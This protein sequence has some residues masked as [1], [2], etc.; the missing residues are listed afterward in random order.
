[1]LIDS[2]VMAQHIVAYVAWMWYTVL[3]VRMNY[4]DLPE[5]VTLLEGH[6][7][8][9]GLLG[10][11]SLHTQSNCVTPNVDIVGEFTLSLE[12]VL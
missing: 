1:M 5:Y 2:A 12:C 6:R 3:R 11:A 8:G 10:Q 9:A 7:S 4:T